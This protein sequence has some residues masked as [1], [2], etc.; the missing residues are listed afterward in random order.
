MNKAGVS[1]HYLYCGAV[2]VAGAAAV[3]C[4]GGF[5]WTAI[6]AAVFVALGVFAGH[7]LAARTRALI[8]AAQQ[9]AIDACSQAL[10]GQMAQYLASQRDL[11]GHVMPIW[12]RQLE[13]SRAQIETAITGLTQRF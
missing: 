4:T 12:T 10:R 7:R 1:Q 5:G 13:M 9:A 8:A 3:I 6:A 2:G 11:S